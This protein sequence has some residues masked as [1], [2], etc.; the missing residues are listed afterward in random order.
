MT[1]HVLSYRLL[2]VVALFGLVLAL[3]PTPSAQGRMRISDDTSPP[4]PVANLTANAGMSPGTVDL[5]WIAPG[6]DGTTGTGASYIVRYNSVPI[7]EDNW[8]NSS[9]IAGEPAPQPAGSV[10]SMAASGLAPS[11]THYFALKTQDEVPN[12]SAVSN[13]SR[14]VATSSP[15]AVYLPLALRSFAVVSPVIPE[16][17]EVLPDTTT[18]YLAAVSGDGAVYTFTQSTAELEEV[19]PGDIMVGDVAGAAPDGFLRKVTSVSSPEG[20]VVVATEPTT[21]E[22]A[23]ESGE[24][25]ISQS[26]IPGQSRVGIR[27][28]GVTLAPSPEKFEY[29]FRDVVLY[30]IDGDPW[31]TDDQIKA[32]GTLALEMGF[33]FSLRVQDFE[34]KDLSFT[35][36]VKETADLEIKCEVELVSIEAER[37]IAR[38]YLSPITVMI[39]PLPVV[40]VPL[41]TVNVGV[42]GSVSV[43]VTTS[44]RQEAR[45]RAGVEY[46]QGFWGP[47]SDFTNE[48]QF[49]PPHLS[50]GLNVKGYA[51]SRLSLLLYG[52]IG[53][54]A[55][56]DGYLELEADVFQ[57]PW[58]TLYGGLEVPVGVTVG[59]LGH[60][61][62]D[63]EALAIG[64]RVV[65]AHA[66][67]NDPPYAP[68]HPTPVNGATD[69]SRNTDLAWMSA[70]PE[71]DAVT[72]DVYLEANDLTPDALV[73]HAQASNS[74]D[75]GLLAAST[76]YYWRIV[77]EDEHGATNAG[78]VWDF[79]TGTSTNGPPNVPSAP[80]PDDGAMDQ[81]I[82]VDLSWTGGDPDGDGVTY[83]VYLEAGDW[84]PDD[85]VCADVVSPSCDPGTLV[86]DTLYFW[87]VVATDEHQAS[88]PGSVWSFTTTSY[89]PDGMVY[90]P[91]G[92]FQMGCDESNPNETCDTDE[93]PLH[94]VYLD[95]YYIDATEVTNAQYALCV[96]AGACAPPL[97]YSSWTRPSYYDNPLYADYPVVHV[98]DDYAQDYCTWAGK[99]LPTE[100]EWE[101]AARGSTDT[102]TYPWGEEP[103]DCSRLN[104][105]PWPEYCVG[106]TTMVGNYPTGASVYGALDMSGNVRE[107]VNDWY[108]SDYYSES[109][110]SNPQ[111]PTSG[112]YRVARSSD[113]GTSDARVAMRT[114]EEAHYWH[115]NWLGFRCVYLTN[116]PPEVPFN[117]SPAQ[118]A[119]QQSTEASLSWAGGDPNWD[120]VTYDVYLEADD[121]TPDLLICDGVG[122]PLCDPGT[123]IANTSYY[124]Q[125][126]ATDEHLV[127]TPGSVWS[128]TTRSGPPGEMV[129]IPAGEFQMGCDESNPS[130]YCMYSQELPLHAVYLDAYYIDVTEVTN[131][132][133]A[134]CVAA[135]AC[136]PPLY[137]Y[138]NTRPSYYDNPLYAHYPVIYVSWY[139]ADDFCTWAGKHLPTEAQ[140]EKA[141]R[142]SSDTW[143]F[144]WG[145]DPADCSRLNYLPWPAY[146]IGDT[147]MVGD[148]PTGASPYGALDMA[149]N[150]DEWVNDWFDGTYYS[151]SPYGNPQGPPSG[152]YRVL[153]NG[154]FSDGWNGCRTASRIGENPAYSHYFVGFRCASSAGR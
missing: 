98:R 78:P 90:I 34:L 45:L 16:T 59:I 32:D 87:Q 108:Q 104:Y 143:V 51:G 50:A 67:D 122:S 125:V 46:A 96:A 92:E 43:G 4:A 138:S 72:Y 127:S 28:P 52:V 19:E 136:A 144:P 81:S 75:P 33:D 36:R 23:V 145:D 150:V 147:T 25:H 149:G 74:Y 6:D 132:Q 99:H 3:F 2:A 79:K 131:A 38:E 21:I 30:D 69:K 68:S 12:T 48:F 39:G 82:D 130:E 137:S 117:P 66:Q 128:F 80:L 126:V 100:A 151:Y 42:D 9:D 105:L 89:S 112:T 116:D 148:Y 84:T 58:W 49:D 85:L 76:H 63:Y 40:I 110:Y 73:S 120:V 88:A 106:D 134:E 86:T 124:W 141:A 57:T 31:T 10:E 102:R 118:G 94:A 101:K 121:T 13:S 91:G 83:N 70:D 56:V 53:P 140:W 35:T 95:A 115:A 65:L 54:Y 119:M 109:P 114:P 27:I 11:R 7:T 123:L 18:R 37:E 62:A 5:Y 133:Y 29:Y 17:T 47:L 111:G 41:L 107:W 55:D 103:R 113:F 61:I 152:T 135:S 22:E 97:D 60:T 139:D 26:L 146:C 14:A 64:Y 1:K 8:A 129:F 20:Q 93:L 153:R 71:G 24:V 44:I 77:A 142:G 154:S 15:N